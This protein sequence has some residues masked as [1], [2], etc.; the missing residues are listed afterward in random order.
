MGVSSEWSAVSLTTSNV[1]G[2]ATGSAP[3]EETLRIADAVLAEC[4]RRTARYSTRSFPSLDDMRGGVWADMAG[5]SGATRLPHGTHEV[6][7]KSRGGHGEVP[8]SCRM[9]ASRPTWLG[10]VE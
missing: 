4:K 5:K 2:T 8:R 9:V 7:M 10:R 3:D 1:G 6:Y